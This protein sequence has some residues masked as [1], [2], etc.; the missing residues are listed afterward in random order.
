SR[1]QKR[2][3][4]FSPEAGRA[5]LIRRAY[6]DLWG[7]P[8]GPAEVDAFLADRRPDAWERLIDRL[9]ASPRF[10]ERWGRHWLDVVGYADT[11]SFDIDA[12]LLIVPDGKWKYRDYVIAAFNCDKP[13]DRCVPEQ[14]DG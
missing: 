2:R 14:L 3:L 1:L 4:S 9:L 13:Y 7:L 10:G 8:P 11:V 12:T 6:L 5:P